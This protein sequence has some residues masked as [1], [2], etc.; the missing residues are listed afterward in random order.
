M[1]VYVCV[2]I[3]MCVCVCVCACALGQY[4]CPKFNVAFVGK[5]VSPNVTSIGTAYNVTPGYEYITDVYCN[6]LNTF[7][8]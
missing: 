5:C 8:F 3:Y 6:A 1:Y 2:C 7:T 4:S